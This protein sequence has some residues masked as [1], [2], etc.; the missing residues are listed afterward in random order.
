MHAATTPY[1]PARLATLFLTFAFSV[2][3]FAT[4]I[5]ALVKSNDQKDL[6]KKQAPAGTTVN[7]DTNDVFQVGCVVTAVCAVLA[8]VSAGSFVLLLLSHSAS[9][10]T[11]KLQG[12]LTSFLTVWL[13]ASLI[14]MTD[15]VANRGAKVSAFLGTVQLPD[16]LIQAVEQQLGVT[17]IYRDIDYLR[18]AVI[19]PWIAFL[20]GAISS[21]LSLAAARR[22]RHAAVVS[23]PAPA[24]APAEPAPS[25]K[26]KGEADVEQV[27]V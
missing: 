6:V 22:A 2:I 18:L 12:L 17:S 5:N 1:R 27:Q 21:V 16:S 23:A 19:L 25:F 13:F 9:T 14:P 3:G 15:F 7:I 10:R 4:G 11:L 8:V 26:E 20:F 24:V